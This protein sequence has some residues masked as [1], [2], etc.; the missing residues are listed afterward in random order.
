MQ[1][2]GVDWMAQQNWRCILADAQ[3]TG[4]T[5]QALFCI[6]ENAAKLC[7]VLVVCPSSVAWNWEREAVKW[8]GTDLK[9]W[10]VEGM[11]DPMPQKNAHLTIIPWDLLHPRLEELRNRGYRSIICDEA[12]YAKNPESLRGQAVWEVSRQC[13]H[14]MLLTGTP[15]VNNVGEFEW[16]KTIIGGDNPPLLRRILEDVAPE[17]PPK[18]R[19]IVPVRLPSALADEYKRASEGFEEWIDEYFMKLLGDRRKVEEKTSRLMNAESLAKVTYLRRIVG[20][21]KVPTIAAWAKSLIKRGESVVIYGEHSDVLDIFCLALSKLRIEY[22]RVDGSSSRTERQMA[23]DGLQRGKVNCFVGSRAA[24]E[25]ITLTR[26]T[27]MAFLERYYTPS[28][29]EQA[30][31]RIRRIGQNQPT[32]I[33]Y[34]E[35][36]GTIDERIEEIV[37][38]KRRIIERN[39]KVEEV[40]TEEI[41]ESIGMLEKLPMLEGLIKPLTVAP[42]IKP[43][44]PKLPDPKLVRA[45]IFDA[46]DWGIPFVT[47]SLRRRGFKIRR[48]RK[49]NSVVFIET[50]TSEAF[51]YGSVHKI[52]VGHRFE[53]MVGKPVQTDAERMKNYRR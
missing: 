24:I 14:V 5:A 18:I 40:H 44:L 45:V 33:W 48:V 11:A 35:A 36:S 10:V 47:K 1:R 16:L 37:S 46:A 29:E 52:V 27:H 22:L 49:K 28:A 13:D 12:H 30:E 42:S 39:L 4:K 26:A 2:E 15:L 8:I 50:K 25:G 32:T 43:K 34:F 53:A 31:D 23:I 17:V 38:R 19:K 41:Q 6:G 3:G 9:T 51:Y 7:P 21:G 20:R